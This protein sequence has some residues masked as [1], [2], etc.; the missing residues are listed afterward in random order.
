LLNGRYEQGRLTHPRSTPFITI[1]TVA[2]TGFSAR[3]GMRMVS[4]ALREVSK[5][6]E[7]LW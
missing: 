7:A 1:N 2:N 6:I 3:S 4:G 5:G